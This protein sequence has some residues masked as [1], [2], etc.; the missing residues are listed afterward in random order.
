MTGKYNEASPSERLYAYTRLP[1]VGKIE[2]F[3]YG[4]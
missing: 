3:F 1:V 4:W 2:G